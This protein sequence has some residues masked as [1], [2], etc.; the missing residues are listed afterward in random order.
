MQ[1]DVSKIIWPNLFLAGVPRA[2]TTAVYAYLRQHPDIFMTPSKEPG[3][4][5]V[6]GA[7]F[8]LENRHKRQQNY[9]LTTIDD[10]QALF[11]HWQNETVIGDATP[12]YIYHRRVAERIA[13]YCPDAKILII[14]RNPAER[15]HSH[16]M[17]DIRDGGKRNNFRAFVQ[18]S[19]SENSP[20]PPLHNSFYAVHLKNFWDTLDSKNIRVVLYD[21][22][23]ANPQSL[24]TSLYEFLEVDITF[25]PEIV[26]QPN[27]SGVPRSRIAH[28][29]VM[30][31]LDHRLMR[32]IH[33]R[34]SK[35]LGNRMESARNRYFD[36]WVKKE[37]LSADEC[38]ALNRAIFREDIEKLQTLIQ[39]D[40]SHW[41]D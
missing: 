30:K 31:S 10:Y 38:K 27:R 23:A 22:L 24:M 8:D 21:D 28:R 19:L 35:D 6:D 33:L 29:L 12:H 7:L 5:A 20:P 32:Q 3:F 25:Q 41:L 9:F 4:F 36:R 1:S 11:R 37:A 16:Y 34:G 18:K 40:L 14:L 39:R 2:G 26:G 17:M 15:M 13:H